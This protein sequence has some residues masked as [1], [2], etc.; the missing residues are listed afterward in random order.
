MSTADRTLI[1][2]LITDGKDARNFK[3]WAAAFG[4]AMVIDG[5][6]KTVELIGDAWAGFRE[7]QKVAA[8]LGVTWKNLGLA[9][10][11]LASTL[12]KVT[13][14]AT[15]LGVSDDEAVMAFNK[16]LQVT[17][18]KDAAMRRLKIAYDLVANGAAPN[19]SSAMDIIRMAA[20]G[21]A[22]VVDKFGLES[23]TAGGRVAELGRKVRG[24]AAEKARL[25]PLGTL[26]MQ[27]DEDL[28]SI[29]GRF[30]TGD[31]DG[32]IE[33]IADAGDHL[34]EAWAKVMPSFAGFAGAG[35]AVGGGLS[36]VGGAL[37]HLG[38]LFGAAGAAAGALAR[39]IGDVLGVA[40]T[41]VRDGPLADFIAAIAEPM[42]GALVFSLDFAKASLQVVTDL[43]N[44]DFG[45]AITD[46]QAGMQ[47]MA[48]T[49]ADAFRKT[50]GAIG[51]LM[52]GIVTAWNNLSLS[53]PAFD[54]KVDG[55]QADILGQKIGLDAQTFRLWEGTGDLIPDLATGGIVR[56]SAGGTIA[57][58]GEGGRDEAVIP[59]GR[60][61]GMGGPT[62][63][64]NVYVAPGGDLV[65]A[66]RQMVRAIQQYEKRGGRV[67]RAA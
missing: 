32:A 47:A 3:K 61:G 12:D 60:G 24:A 31:I 40:F 37:E 28:E 29:V 16:A 55:F 48:D 2:R 50:V 30:V 43:L 62:Y 52:G 15:K 19:L 56:A 11:G 54:F 53:I 39:V 14:S 49:V 58:L 46:A 59:L 34:A 27:M 23:K 1:L 66:G 22:R 42:A 57:R 65:E 25:D 64:L 21:S 10:S 41:Q 13:S 8:Q 26:F 44:G 63:N 4:G 45:K 7:G 6:E 67:W 38:Q 35:T 36:V 18:D 5:L 17:K 33:A 51:E 9:G 20:K